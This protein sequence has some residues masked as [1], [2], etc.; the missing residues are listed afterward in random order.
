[1]SLGFAIFPCKGKAP[2]TAHGV[3]DASKNPEQIAKWFGPGTTKNIGI[4]CG[5]P[6]GVFVLDSDNAEDLKK[7]EDQYGLLPK[8]W[9]VRTGGGEERRQF[10]FRFDDRCTLLK[11]AT[12]FA[13]SLDIRTTG[14][15]VIAPPSIHPVTQKRYEWIVSPDECEL[16]SAPDWLLALIPKH[17]ET[18]SAKSSTLTIQ[19]AKTLDERVGLF[20]ASAP[21]AVSGQ[22]GHGTTFGVCCAL[23]E[24]FGT[25]DDETLLASLKEWNDRCEPPW[26]ENDLRRKV[27]E[28]RKRGVTPDAEDDPLPRPDLP[29]LEDE[30][31]HGLASDVLR[32]LEPSTEAAPAA[33]LLTFLTAFSVAVGRNPHFIVEGRKVHPNLYTAVVG[34]SSRSRKGTSLGRVQDLFE[35]VNVPKL[36]GL[37]S[38]EGLIS[39]LRDDETSQV[40]GKFVTAGGVQDKRLWIIESEFARTLKTMKREGNSLSAILRDAWDVGDIASMTKGNPLRASGV[41]LGITTHIT[42]DELRQTMADVDAVNGFA[43]RF[44]WSFVTKSKSLPFGGDDLDTSS[45]RQRVAEV[46][47][48]AKTIGRMTRSSEANTLWA[49]GYKSLTDEKESPVW[50]SVTSRAEGQVLRLSMLFALLDCTP[51]IEVGHLRSALAVW[52]FCDDSARLLFSDVKT[53]PESFE[54][55]IVGHVRNQPGLTRT[56]LRD[57]FHHSTK[58][59]DLFNRTLADLISR[60]VIVCVPCFCAVSSTDI[61]IGRRGANSTN[62]PNFTGRER[63]GE[64]IG[65]PNLPNLTLPNSE[66]D[67]PRR[68]LRL[69]ERQC[70]L[71]HEARRRSLLG[72]SSVRSAPDAGD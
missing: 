30:A 37:S 34:R 24:N 54:S 42:S 26:K 3:K 19:R 1:M 41:H 46:V 13:G 64:R 33:L 72:Y 48:K 31:Y 22:N 20:L 52:S 11:N 47:E 50:D 12:K 59:T 5:K 16:A 8:T 35:S 69:E 14:G 18:V 32:T 23:V 10:Y 56:E 40:Q 45:L 58:M 17:G 70:G 28:A 6:S 21:V 67:G 49:L 53:K 62:L 55:K 43:N 61:G 51:V 65:D 4:A 36:S 9:T 38:G 68:V 60:N 63:S 25:L 2:A 7:L 39:A 57:K 44:L 27:L 66:A 15:Y 71:V 29:L